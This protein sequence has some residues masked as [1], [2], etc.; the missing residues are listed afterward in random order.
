ME[1]KP[2]N[3]GGQFGGGKKGFGRGRGKGKGKA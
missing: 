3:T 1:K 2:T